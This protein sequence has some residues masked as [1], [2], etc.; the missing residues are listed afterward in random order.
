MQENKT[1]SF[2]INNIKY[3]SNKR[4]TVWEYL[5]SIDIEIPKV[6]HIENH[7]CG[8]RCKVCAV[9]INDIIT[10]SCN[11]YIE[12]NINI[13]THSH[14]AIQARLWAT[15]FLLSHHPA[16]CHSCYKI[17]ECKLAIAFMLVGKNTHLRYK[18][19]KIEHNI[20]TLSN[21]LKLDYSLCVYCGLCDDENA[22]NETTKNLCPTGALI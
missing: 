4:I 7:T 18:P 8:G 10:S 11:T 20:K 9:E 3:S 2:F 17:G 13:V 6:C 19:L 5:Q 21:I 15:R 16:Y 12:N 14:D 1:I 22:I